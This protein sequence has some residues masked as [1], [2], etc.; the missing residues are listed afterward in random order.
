MQLA[1][2]AAEAGLRTQPPDGDRAV[3]PNPGDAQSLL[4]REPSAAAG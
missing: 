1:A 4:I 3:A 2:T